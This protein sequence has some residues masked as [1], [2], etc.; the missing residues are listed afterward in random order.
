VLGLVAL[1]ALALTAGALVGALFLRH[2][3][4][5]P[6]SPRSGRRT[7]HAIAQRTDHGRGPVGML[8]RRL[9]PAEATGLALTLVFVGIVALF[10]LGFAVRASR[11]VVDLDR[12]VS[13]W[14]GRTVDGVPF[15]VADLLTQLGGTIGVVLIAV[16]V[17][18]V[19]TLRTRSRWIAPFLAIALIGQSVA[20]N[21]IKAGV[22]RFRPAVDPVIGL[23]NDSFPSG[24]AAAAAATFAAC[25]FLLS[26]RR[27]PHVQAVITGV[28]VS[29]AV[30]VGVS[31]VL[32]TYH[33]PSDVVAGLLLGW[34]W[35][36]VCA[37]AFG[38]R[39]L[40]FGAPVE[41]G[42]RLAALGAPNVDVSRR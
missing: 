16:A 30:A 15:D 21:L 22:G 41:A 17:A 18:G 4:F 9:N 29:M 39:L 38:G 27:A 31:R 32:L 6:A 33:W 20:A 3:A 35:F 19:E 13:D 23:G 2:P 24:H 1:L 5:D 40:V 10:V 14:A 12:T 26:R 34:G 8:L 36:G 42:E 37:I 25:A 7:A 28:G 11:P